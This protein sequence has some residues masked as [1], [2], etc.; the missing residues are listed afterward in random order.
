MNSS[1]V[2]LQLLAM[3]PPPVRRHRVQVLHTVIQALRTVVYGNVITIETSHS[4]R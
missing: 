1:S 2:N 3:T 4:I